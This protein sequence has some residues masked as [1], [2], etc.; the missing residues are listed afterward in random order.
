MR[1]LIIK[2]MSY[3]LYIDP[4]R[5]VSKT[6]HTLFKNTFMLYV[7][8]FSGYFFSLITIPYQ[9]RVLGPTYMGHV[10]FAVSMMVFFGLFIDY[11]FLLYGTSE[12]SKNRHDKQ[13]VSKVLTSAT[14]I[15]VVLSVISLFLLG[16][17][18]L[19]APAVRNDF[20]LFAF[21]LF[22]VIVGSM[23][24]D[25]IYRG[26]ENMTAITVRSV[27]TKFVFAMLIFPLV[28]KPSDYYIIPLLTLAG[29]AVALVGVYIHLNKKVRVGFS[30]V[31]PI[32]TYKMFKESTHFFLSR[33]AGSVYSAGN[34]LVLGS[35]HPG[36]SL[37]YYV[38]SE[39][40]VETAKG[41]LYPVSDSLY[42]YMI[43]SK[44]F[45]LIARVMK[46]FMPLI[47]VAGVLTFI[48]AE[49]ICTLLF[50]PSFIHA[51]PV[52]RALTPVLVVIFPAYLLGFPTLGAMGLARHANRSIFVALGCQVISVL[53]L[54]ALHRVT[55]VTLA[56]STSI[57]ET[58][59]LIYRCIVIYRY[60]SLLK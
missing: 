22:D 29:N 14:M 35:M 31:D 51:A 40:L 20:W 13:Y 52:L 42:P 1:N 37:G 45:K 15:K 44:D 59:V 56:V 17:L 54:F 25:Y 24:P 50:G 39:R 49:Y 26:V 5:W 60:R 21:F 57:S 36:A 32:Y 19:F 6:H 12:V 46:I 9:A 10:G 41:L 11:G 8:Q 16:I 55:M 7:L 4:R 3:G 53:A 38:T 2:I 34:A 28:R 43:R 30:R 27:F 33:I 58:A 48:F 47:V 18:Y 23:I